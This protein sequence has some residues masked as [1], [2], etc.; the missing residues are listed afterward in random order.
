VGPLNT[1]QTSDFQKKSD[2]LFLR[3]IV[4]LKIGSEFAQFCFFFF[5]TLPRNDFL[6]AGKAERV[7]VNGY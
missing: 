2:F 7:N 1:I 6:P 4:S 5:Q 3:A